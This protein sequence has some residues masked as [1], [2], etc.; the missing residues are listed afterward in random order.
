M[1][2]VYLDNAKNPVPKFTGQ[3]LK[4]VSIRFLFERPYNMYPQTENDLHEPDQSTWGLGSTLA[5][6]AISG[7]LCSHSMAIR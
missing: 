3:G 6:S 1:E 2:L 5:I 4:S 7:T